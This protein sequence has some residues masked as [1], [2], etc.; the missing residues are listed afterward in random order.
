[1]AR[2]DLYANGPNGYLLDVQ[3]DLISGLNSRLVAPLLPL[4]FAPPP[5]RKLHPVFEI[6]G[7][8]HVLATHLLG[9]VP[10]SALSGSVG[11]LDAHHDQ[12]SAA[13]DMIFL[14]F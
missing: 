12:I 14:G 8:L 10:M 9:A 1:V 7:E 11:N 5:I 3:T 2:F 4:A 6:E 13:L